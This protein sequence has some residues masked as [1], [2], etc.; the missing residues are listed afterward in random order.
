MG[1][2]VFLGVLFAGAYM[3]WKEKEL[4]SLYLIISAVLGGVFAVR[5]LA[6]GES[7]MALCISCSVGICLLGISYMT[8]GGVGEGD[9]WFFVISG[10]FLPWNEN[11]FLLCSGWC[12]CFLYSLAAVGRSIGKRRLNLSRSVPFL[13]FL[14][15]AGILLVFF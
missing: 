14:V 6:L 8:R 9:G 12:F 15:P 4:N 13:P 3:D 11:V 1:K 7:W 10:L 2:M 5:N